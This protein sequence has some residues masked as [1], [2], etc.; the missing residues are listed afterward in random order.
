MNGSEEQADREI[1]NRILGGDID[2]FEVFLDRYRSYVFKILSGHLPYDKVSDIA[3]EVFV[4]AYESLAS[5]DNRMTFKKWI[6]AISIHRAY[7]YWRAH[8]RNR[9]DTMSSLSEENEQW[10]DAATSARSVDIFN[11]EESQKEAHEV[12][13]KAL[14]FLS[15]EDRMVLS[16]VHLEGL[17][18][19]EAAELLGWG[20]VNVK[21]RAYRSRE[22]LRKVITSMLKGGGFR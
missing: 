12:L 10:L 6:A 11:R 14:A 8:Y 18:V 3:H 16:L 15:P 4:E 20:V 13:Q 9:E 1:V 22:K 5:F 17:S 2:A 7:D 19:K 21:V